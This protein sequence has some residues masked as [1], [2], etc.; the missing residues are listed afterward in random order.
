MRFFKLFCFGLSGVILCTVSY[1]RA[2]QASPP[3]ANPPTPKAS[4]AKAAPIEKITDN[5]YRLGTLLIDMKAHTLTCP[6]EINMDSGDVEYLAV[7]PMGKTYESL[8]RLNVRPLYLQLG[9]LLL[10]LEPKNV[11]RYQGDPTSPQGDPVDIL[12]RWA[13]RNGIEHQ[14]RAED[15]LM[16]GSK[17]SPMPHHPWVFTGSRILPEGFEADLCGS[18]V[19][20]WH[21]PAAILDNPMQEIQNDWMVNPAKT[22]RRGTSIR[23]IFKAIHVPK[24]TSPSLPQHTDPDAKR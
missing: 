2:I 7:T 22:P 23:V 14:V 17:G 13:D 24:Q 15:L 21:D 9:L 4:A 20:V 11:L 10:G 5:L 12:V 18:L 19:A 3:P 8:L 1:L 6:G 16:E